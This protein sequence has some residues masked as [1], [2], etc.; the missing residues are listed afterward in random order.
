[1]QDINKADIIC[2]TETHL[3]KEDEPPNIDGYQAFHTLVNRSEYLGR[4]IKGVSIYYKNNITNTQINEMLSEN[5]NLIILKLTNANWEESEALFL[6]VCYREDRESKFKTD[7]YFENIKR[8]ITEFKMKHIFIIGDLNGR[9]G[10]LN[11]NEE[12]KFRPRDS[13]DLIING[14]G[15]NIID[16]CNETTL[17]IAN[18]RLEKGRCTFFSLHKGDVKKSVIDYLILSCSLIRNINFFEIEPPVPY[19]DHAPMK[20]TIKMELK[21]HNK[22]SNIR[23]LTSIKHHKKNTI[24]P[25]KWNN[26]SNFNDAIFKNKCNLLYN[27]MAKE[28]MTSNDIFAEL[29]YNKDLAVSTT[30]LKGQTN[31]IVY[32]EQLRKC[33]QKYKLNVI[34]YKESRLHEQLVQLLKAKKE[35]NKILRLERRKNKLIK[36]QELKIAK[37]AHNHKK[38]WYLL[39]QHKTKKKKLKTDLKATDFKTQ[40]EKRYVDQNN[41][42]VEKSI[43]LDETAKKYDKTF[44]DELNLEITLEEV[45]NALKLAQKS[46]SSGPDGIVYEMLKN[47]TQETTL[48]L[49]KLFNNIKNNGQIPWNT[50]WIL[51]IYKNG[52]KNSPS[53]YRCINLS[54]SIEK[55]LTKIMNERLSKWIEKYDIINPEQTGFRKGN[56]VLDNILLLKEIITIYKKQKQPVYTCFVD[57]SKAFDSVPLNKLKSKLHAIIPEGNFLSLIINLLDNKTYK[58]LHNGEE[59]ESFM[60]TGGIP[61]GDSMSPTLFCLYINDLVDILHQNE[62]LTDPILINDMKIATVIYADDILLM[63]QSQEGIIKQIKIVQNFCLENGL[64]INYEKTKIMIAN[65]KTKY[66][67]V[68]IVAK[69]TNHQIEIVD[70]YK[71][72]GMWINEK[73]SNKHHLEHLEKIGRKSSF[74]TTKI[75]KEFGQINGRFLCET[76]EMLSLSKMKYSGELCFYDNLRNLNQI[77]NQF[78]KRFCHLKVTTPNYCLIG[79]FGIK[80]VEYHFCKS[81]LRYWLKLLKANEKNFTKKLYNEIATNI[82]DP[83]FS[84]TWCGRIKNLLCD[85]KLEDLWSNQTTHEKISYKQKI[86]VRLKE[87]FREKWITSAKLSNKGI[88]YLELALFDCETKQYLNYIMS[89]KSVNRML[90]LRTG[91]HVLAVETERYRNRKAY[92][93]RLCNFCEMGKVQDL[94]HV[95]VECPKFVEVR[96]K[97]VKFDNQLSKADLYAHLNNVTHSQL[98]AIVQIMDVVEET[99]KNN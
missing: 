17:I 77:Q 5:G 26:G 22:S 80:P 56:S 85:L 57:L 84:H 67:Y 21:E 54:S 1:M 53:S 81:A 20:V 70:N 23:T 89:D 83:R 19:T 95:I 31:K 50:S 37:D 35:Y 90:K 8:Y 30:Q 45:V 78:F 86:D 52:D 48:I 88:D 60:L 32:S 76:F 38:Y 82:E 34:Q 51:P 47:S 98:K 14:Q 40:I 79:E 28:N 99:I 4:N 24:K 91:N 72:L 75:L 27:R 97:N 18:G 13:D 96:S 59:T 94:Y 74:M 66:K 41:S 33:R 25:Y 11:D 43:E 65:S 9:I 55:L 68:E 44:D 93:E 3:K 63:S 6:I 39:N 36:L 12:F 92:N 87:Y 2:F 69:N 71:Y 42:I 64:K 7:D 46:K 73:N 61:Q 58:V 29:I 49:A 10:R 15:K 16:F 62:S